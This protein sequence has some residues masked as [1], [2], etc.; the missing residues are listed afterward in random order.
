MIH[1][2]LDTSI[3]RII[4]KSKIEIIKEQKLILKILPYLQNQKIVAI[5]TNLE[6]IFATN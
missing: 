3:S 5:F 2:I 4:I 6:N 1:F